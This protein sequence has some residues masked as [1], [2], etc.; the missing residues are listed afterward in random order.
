MF[1]GMIN[2]P[3]VAVALNP[4]PENLVSAQKCLGA[5]KWQTNAELRELVIFRF[6]LPPHQ[7]AARRWT[8]CSDWPAIEHITAI[9]T[10]TPRG[11]CMAPLN[12]AADGLPRPLC[13]L[14][15]QAQLP[16]GPVAV[17]SL[18]RQHLALVALVVHQPHPHISA[19]SQLA[20][21]GSEGIQ[22]GGGLSIHLCS[23]QQAG[24][25]GRAGR[26]KLEPWAN[27]VPA[28]LAA[29]LSV[30]STAAAATPSHAAQ[31]PHPLTCHKV[32]GIQAVAVGGAAVV[33]AA[34][35][36]AVALWQEA[37]LAH[38]TVG[39]LQQAGRQA[40]GRAGGAC[41]GT[42]WHRAG[43]GKAG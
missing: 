28:T 10:N 21:H 26:Q 37:Q 33:P 18:Q 12:R 14:R 27:A 4:T 19:V 35:V 2:N 7:R 17:V 29:C 40:G 1:R 36:D 3:E 24:T 43:Q 34:D 25:R 23:G 41:D 11:A 6:P 9:A 15:V 30:H 22:I 38:A 5:F 16:G 39:V 13:R 8:H 42:E 31:P 20:H 32:Q